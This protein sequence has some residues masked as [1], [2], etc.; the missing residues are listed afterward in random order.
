MATVCFDNSAILLADVAFVVLILCLLPHRGNFL[1]GHG[2]LL[3]E[4]LEVVD[5]EVD[6][7]EK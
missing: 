1:I 5:Y 4:A 7:D 3:L 2:L 6:D